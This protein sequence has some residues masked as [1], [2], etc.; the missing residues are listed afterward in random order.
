MNWIVSTTINPVTEAIRKFDAMEGWTLLVTGDRKTPDYRLER[1]VYLDWEYQRETYPEICKLVGPDNTQRGRMIGFIEAHKRG[2][3]LLATIDD[4]CMPYDGWPGPVYV[5]RSVTVDCYRIKDPVFDPFAVAEYEHQPRGYPPQLRSRQSFEKY[6]G[7]IS[8]LMQANLWDGEIDYDACWRV[9]GS[10][11]EKCRAITPFWSPALSPVNTQ[12]TII[13]GSVLRDHCGEMPFVG[14]VG[15]VWAGYLF[16]A[17]HPATTIYC[18]AT[19]R[20]WQDRTLESVLK[21]LKEEMHSYQ[22]G[23]KFIEGLRDSGP[24]RIAELLPAKTIEAL[25]IYRSYFE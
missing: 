17:L 18:P 23:L 16:Q 22:H 19:V 11:Y 5:G 9:H 10:K 2:C 1:G 21:D 4:D 25:S 7:P 13:D 20:H 12:N 8:P 14:H 3:E 6:L 15:D 24:E